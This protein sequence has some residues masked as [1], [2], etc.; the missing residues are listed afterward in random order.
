M[1]IFKLLLFNDLNFLTL[2]GL[3]IGEY[4]SY[5]KPYR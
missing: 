3:S 1:L 4:T 5:L 2:N